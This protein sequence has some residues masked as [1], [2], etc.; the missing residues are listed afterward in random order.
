MKPWK[1]YSG[2]WGSLKKSS[3]IGEIDFKYV[4]KWG[5]GVGEEEWVLGVILGWKV[6]GR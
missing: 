6:G 1:S 4:I 3:Y 5:D 2:L